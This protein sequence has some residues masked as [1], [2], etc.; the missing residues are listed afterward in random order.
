MRGGRKM[1]ILLHVCC[2]P[3]SIYP[4]DALEKQGHELRGYFYNPNIHP[5]TE[6]WR[7]RET[8]QAYA[9]KMGLPVIWDETDQMEDYFR[10]V[11]FREGERCRLC[12]SMRLQ[13]AAQIAKKGKFDAFTTT[14]LVSPFQRH[15]LIKELGT[16]IGA[17]VGVP[18]YYEDFRVGF[19][20]GVAKSKEEQMYRQQY[21]GCIFSERE[22]YAACAK[23]KPPAR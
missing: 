18:F 15:D 23:Q 20:E 4:L 13:K 8:F 14:L 16:A 5:F 3:C 17:Q 6:Y 21:C 9:E 7:R 12:Y 11:A 1:K 19:K 2:G 22:R 10:N